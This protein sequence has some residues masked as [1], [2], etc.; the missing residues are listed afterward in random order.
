MGS[1]A[2]SDECTKDTCTS[3]GTC[4]NVAVDA[5]GD[6]CFLAEARGRDCGGLDCDDGSDDGNPR[7][8]ESS[9]EDDV[10]QDCRG[11]NLRFDAARGVGSIG[12]SIALKASLD[13][14]ERALAC[15]MEED[16]YIVPF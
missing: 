3:W 1:P 16:D 15:D 7:M 14:Y 2:R 9:C 12:Q 5:D 13:A 6:G 10:D 11:T 8:E 4:A